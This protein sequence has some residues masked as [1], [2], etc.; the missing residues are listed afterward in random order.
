MSLS[1]PS[2]FGDVVE[3]T[4]EQDARGYLGAALVEIGAGCGPYVKGAARIVISALGECDG[5]TRGTL[6]FRCIDEMDLRESRPAN[7]AIDELVRRSIVHF[8]GDRVF[9]NPAASEAVTRDLF[10]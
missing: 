8:R 9:L 5:I 7:V 10:R 6:V 2:P 1:S 4:I 3:P